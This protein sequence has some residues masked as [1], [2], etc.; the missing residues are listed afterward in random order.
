MVNRQDSSQLEKAPTKENARTI[1]A[2]KFFSIDSIPGYFFNIQGHIIS[3]SKNGK[4]ILAA[5]QLLV[6]PWS[7]DSIHN[8]ESVDIAKGIAIF[9]ALHPPYENMGDC[10]QIVSIDTIIE[11]NTKHHLRCFHIC[12]TSR[13]ICKNIVE[14]SLHY[15]GYFLDVSNGKQYAIIMIPKGLIYSARSNPYVAINLMINSIKKS[16]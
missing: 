9:W 14:D 16:E 4:R 12:A 10:A 7:S 3:L 2:Q 1:N 6:E 11:F 13:T 5:S 15:H 8:L